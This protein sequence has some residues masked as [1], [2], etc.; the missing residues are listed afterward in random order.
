MTLTDTTEISNHCEKKRHQL[1]RTYEDN[2]YVPVC[3]LDT[4]YR[5]LWRYGWV[6]AAK[7]LHFLKGRGSQSSMAAAAAL[8]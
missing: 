7:D 2:V 4:L 8:A 1:Y 3:V 5:D 6:I